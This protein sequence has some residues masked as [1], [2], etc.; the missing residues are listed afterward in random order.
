MLNRLM[1][2]WNTMAKWDHDWFSQPRDEHILLIGSLATALHI[3]SCGAA[4]FWDDRAAV[5]C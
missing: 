3:Q 2:W 4:F 5:V 1:Q